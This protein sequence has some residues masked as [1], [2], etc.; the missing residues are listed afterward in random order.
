MGTI[1]YITRHGQT[2]W[3][4]QRKMQGWKD[5]P[6]T[7]LGLKQ[8]KRLGKRLEDDNIDIIYSSPLGRALKT[9]K[10]IR[11]QRDISILCDERLKEIKL[12]KWEGIEHYVID[13]DYKE[14]IYNF[15][16]N[17]KLYKSVEGETFLQLRNRVKDFLDEIIKKHKNKTILI[18]THA[19]TLKAI[20]NYIEDLTIDNF[21]GEPHINP[22]SLTKVEIEESNVKILLNADISHL[23][24]IE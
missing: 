6:L 22:T 10:I 9:A 1:L 14:E 8:A 4:T 17:P 2:I 7:Q 18:V 23:D 3:N 5:S 24:G 15:W 19:I 20:M 21:W 16:N 13:S 11:G 12:G